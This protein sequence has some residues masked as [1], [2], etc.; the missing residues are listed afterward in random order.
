MAPLADDVAQRNAA[1]HAPGHC[2]VQR[3]A[4]ASPAFPT[5]Q[6]PQRHCQQR[7]DAPVG[8]ELPG[9]LH[10]YKPDQLP[11]F[12]GPAAA[13]TRTGMPDKWDM[14]DRGSTLAAPSEARILT[15]A[16]ARL[17]ATDSPRAAW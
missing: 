3:P 1:Q 14:P 10:A 6:P 17:L 13:C 11:R 8:D 9:E 5:H 16:P 15:L 12:T 2:Q 7:G 4:A